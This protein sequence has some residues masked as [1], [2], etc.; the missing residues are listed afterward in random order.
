MFFKLNKKCNIYYFL[1]VV[2][3]LMMVM[4]TIIITVN[5]VMICWGLPGRMST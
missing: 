2:V 3:M 4:T 1:V 5:D